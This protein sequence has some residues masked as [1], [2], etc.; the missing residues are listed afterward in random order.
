M[1]CAFSQVAENSLKLSIAVTASANLGEQLKKNAMTFLT[2]LTHPN[3]VSLQV[4][5]TSKFS[6]HNFGCL[7]WIQTTRKFL[8]I[9]FDSSTNAGQVEDAK[10]NEACLLWITIFKNLFCCVN[11]KCTN[12]SSGCLLPL[13][14]SVLS[15]EKHQ[16]ICKLHQSEV[17][18]AINQEFSE[19]LLLLLVWPWHPL[20]AVVPILLSSHRSYFSGFILQ[21][22]AF[23]GSALAFLDFFWSH[24]HSA[25]LIFVIFCTPTHFLG[26]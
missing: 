20:N 25:Y 24:Y 4:K 10:I 17:W 5:T 6:S 23:S 19:S 2:F 12:C 15:K 22:S 21:T 13:S 1:S 11:N 18:L 26:R 7:Q 14:S 9:N 16:P 8:P 3:P